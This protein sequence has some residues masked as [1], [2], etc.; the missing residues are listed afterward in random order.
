MK[1][2]NKLGSNFIGFP[3]VAYKMGLD[4]AGKPTFT[5]VGAT[6][7]NAAGR[8]GIGMLRD[9]HSRHKLTISQ[10]FLQSQRTRASRALES[11]GSLILLLVSKRSTPYQLMVC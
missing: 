4:S 6:A 7:A 9:F 5:Q 8:V 11:S 10:G 3:T 2:S 1:A